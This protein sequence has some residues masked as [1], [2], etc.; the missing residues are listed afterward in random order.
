MVALPQ[1]R[2]IGIAASSDPSASSPIQIHR[3]RVSL[4]ALPP[5]SVLL[6]LVNLLIISTTNL[7]ARHNVLLQNNQRRTFLPQFKISEAKG[8][9]RPLPKQDTVISLFHATK[10]RRLKQDLESMPQHNFAL[11]NYD[12]LHKRANDVTY[13]TDVIGILSKVF[14]IEDFGIKPGRTKPLF[15]KDVTLTNKRGQ[16][17]K[18]TLWSEQALEFENILKNQT[19]TEILFCSL[20]NFPTLGSYVNVGKKK[21]GNVHLSSTSATKIYSN[22]NIKEANDLR[23]RMHNAIDQ[24]FEI[25]ML[26][27]PTKPTIEEIKLANR[28]TIDQIL[29][30]KFEDGQKEQN[31]QD[32]PRGVKNFVGRTFIFQVKITQFNIEKGYEDYTVNRVFED[33]DIAEE[34]AHL[35]TAMQVSKN[36]DAKDDTQKV[37]NSDT[38]TKRKCISNNSEAGHNATQPNDDTSQLEDSE[39]EE[40]EHVPIVK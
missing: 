4:T 16:E 2:S 29:N 17:L 30:M 10:V 32:I 23:E 34:S 8:T 6:I 25:E 37:Q 11:I 35:V 20:P 18:V 22:L 33:T 36:P 26:P 13:L 38:T 24:N 9:Y 1:F 40:R 12:E 15:K 14:D 3:R 39:D 27:T 21:T 19:T 31:L 28:L 5:P 7:Q